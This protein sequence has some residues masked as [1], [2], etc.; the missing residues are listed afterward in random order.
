MSPL[1]EPCPYTLTRRR[2]T[3]ELP[4]V[5]F[6]SSIKF[7]PARTSVGRLSAMAKRTLRVISTTQSK[8]KQ[9]ACLPSLR[10]ITASTF[11]GLRSKAQLVVPKHRP[12]RMMTRR[13][14]VLRYFL[15]A[16]I[17]L[18]TSTRMAMLLAV[19]RL[20]TLVGSSGLLI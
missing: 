3:F 8:L 11:A 13:S 15:A 2:A 9:R 4:P 1:Q 16:T 19:M 20:I 18:D 5:P 12:A 14:L 10:T 6:A 7:L 17:Q